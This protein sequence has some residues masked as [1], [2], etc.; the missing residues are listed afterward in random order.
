MNNED[1][2]KTLLAAADTIAPWLAYKSYFAKEGAPYLGVLLAHY[3]RQLEE[4]PLLALPFGIKAERVA[5]SD[6]CPPCGMGGPYKTYSF[7]FLS[8][9]AK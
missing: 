9:Y 8:F 1:V 3:T 6:P 5:G 2:W 4:G 7:R